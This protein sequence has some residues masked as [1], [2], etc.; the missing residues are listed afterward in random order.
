MIAFNRGSVPEVVEDGLTGF[1]VEDEAAVIAAVGCL[2]C[3]SRAT[4]RARFEQ[5]FTARRMAEDYLATYSRLAADDRPVVRRRLQIWAP[6]DDPA[7]PGRKSRRRRANVD[8][9]RRRLFIDIVSR[10]G[11][12]MARPTKSIAAPNHRGPSSH[13][14][15]RA[16]NA[17]VRD[18]HSIMAIYTLE[19]FEM[20]ADR[21]S[22]AAE[23][24]RHGLLIETAPDRDGSFHLARV[25]KSIWR[26]ARG[27]TRAFHLSL[28]GQGIR[29]FC[30]A[31]RN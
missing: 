20:D 4:V 17:N 1:I 11:Q 10:A 24:T 3:L 31:R 8:T 28:H 14:R 16:M 18:R 21:N 9:A 12:V 6:P 23:T 13:S 7:Q 27:A 22:M 15:G 5:R 30:H 19:R 25:T 26:G 29:V 2:D